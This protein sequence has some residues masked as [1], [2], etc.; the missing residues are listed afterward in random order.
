ML[1][2]DA[3]VKYGTKAVEIL[4]SVAEGVIYVII[5]FA[6]VRYVLAI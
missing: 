6:W 5:A 2:A 4:V 1:Y 3:C